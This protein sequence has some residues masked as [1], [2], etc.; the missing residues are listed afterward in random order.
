[1][2][3]K[4][5]SAKAGTGN[6]KSPSILIRPITRLGGLDNIHVALLALVVILMALLML[7]SYYKP[8]G[9][10]PSNQTTTAI[11]PN[12]SVYM[13]HTPAQIKAIAERLIAGY[14]MTNSS[15]SVLPYITNVSAM[16]VSYVPSMK[17]WYVQAPFRSPSSNATVYFSALISDA[18]G[19]LVAPFMQAARPPQSGGQVVSQGVVKLSGRSYCSVQNPLRVSWFID[20]YAPGAIASLKNLTELQSAYPDK[21][22][23]SVDILYG[24]SFQY[25]ANSA[26]TLNAQALGKYILCSSGQQR[27]PA[28]VSALNS[29][30]DNGYLSPNALQSISAT[31]GINQTQLNSC[32]AD[33]GSAI[34]AQAI[35]AQYYNITFTP[36]VIVNC[37]YQ[38]I[39]QTAREA[40]CYANSTICG[41]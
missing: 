37:E 26:G 22:N 30:Y 25:I 4:Q 10:P 36:A 29:V 39:P 5:G 17:D 9:V 19:G 35:L 34:N 23:I 16:T 2:A 33:S 32:I 18:T 38:A 3:G 6:I 40:I 21:V 8:I 20:P 28:F 31:A 13:I 15:I 24:S 11:P 1:M 14:A 7:I 27:F 12:Y 41:A